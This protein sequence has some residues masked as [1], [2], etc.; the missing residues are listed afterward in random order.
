MSFI[1]SEF[2]KEQSEKKSIRI[3]KGNNNNNNNN[4]E[5]IVSRGIRR[6]RFNPNQEAY[7]YASLL[8]DDVMIDA[9]KVLLYS[10]RESGSTL[11]FILLVLPQVKQTEDLIKL[12]ATLEW[13]DPLEYPFKVTVEKTAI[14]KMCR[15]SK[16]QIWKMIQFSKIVF[17][18]VDCLVVQV[19]MVISLIS[20]FLIATSHLSPPHSSFFLLLISFL[21]LESRC[22]I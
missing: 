19:M 1:L 21:F 18:D 6:R 2:F 10:L 22:I 13:I 7:A 14:N 3:I 15:Y 20:H 5:N 4:N 12:G 9:V 11:P 17:I 8:C 16:L